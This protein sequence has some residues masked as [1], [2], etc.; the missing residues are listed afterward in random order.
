MDRLDFIE[1]IFTLY[2]VKPENN[3]D[4]VTIYD[5]AFSVNKAIDWDKLYS[6]VLATADGAL[7]KPAWFTSQFDGCLKPDIY[8]TPDGLR[9]RAVL[10]NGYPYDIESYQ[11]HR[12]FEE[13]KRQSRQFGKNI[14]HLEM[15]DDTGLKWIE[16]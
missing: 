5:E 3:K 6:R 11:E 4:L 12:T 1:K 15:F 13:I 14:D 2:R 9:L 8:N 16:I 10:K 7:P